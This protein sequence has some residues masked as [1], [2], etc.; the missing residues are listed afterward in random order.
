M[1]FGDVRLAGLV[2]GVLGYVSWSAVIVGGF[3]AFVLGAAVGSGSS[4]WGAAAARP[5]C[6]SAP[7]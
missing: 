6:P 1:G 5:P 4:P 3:G 7:S 2:G